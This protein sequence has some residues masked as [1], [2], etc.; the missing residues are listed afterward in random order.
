MPSHTNVTGD[1]TLGF[2]P[3]DKL[4]TVVVPEICG[5]G[6]LFVCVSWPSPAPLP[7]M[8]L[9]LDMGGEHQAACWSPVSM[10]REAVPPAPL[11][12]GIRGC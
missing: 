5:M 8:P 12:E 1:I 4:K 10:F 2:N 11:D 6:G 9:P 7:K 3:W